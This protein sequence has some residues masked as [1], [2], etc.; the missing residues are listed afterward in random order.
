[1][2]NG[3]SVLAIVLAR[4]G[5]TRLP[6]K[7]TLPFGSDTVVGT[8]IELAKQ[9]D[10][11]DEVVLATSTSADDTLFE[12]IAL[13]HGITLIRGSENDVVARMRKAV[14]GATANH[15]V[16]VR[17]CADNPLFMPP[18]VD[19]G[20]RTLAATGADML[21]P[22]EHATLPFGYA[23]VVMT[24]ECLERIDAE[25]DLPMYREHVENF[26]L[27]N[28]ERFAIHYQMAP[29][30]MH[31]PEL[32][33]TLDYP[34]DYMRLRAME[35]MVAD[36]PLSSRAA[37]LICRIK[38]C[39]VG[40]TGVSNAIVERLTPLIERHCGT[41]PVVIDE[42]SGTQ[43]GCDLL[44]SARPVQGTLLERCLRGAIWVEERPGDGL[45][46]VYGHREL[47]SPYDVGGF[48]GESG[49]FEYYLGAQM[50]F[51]LKRFLPGFPPG[52]GR[53]VTAVPHRDK[54]TGEALRQGF[55]SAQAARFPEV[56]AVEEGEWPRNR[57]NVD[58]LL[59]LAAQHGGCV[60]FESMIN[61]DNVLSGQVGNASS[62]ER[63]WGSLVWSPYAVLGISGSGRY[64]GCDW[65]GHR[66][67]IGE[68]ASMSV[69]EAWNASPM[70]RLRANWV[71]A[72]FG[73]ESRA[74]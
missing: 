50:E 8:V 66:V 11:V 61:E 59:I 5:A 44:F 9:C 22:W 65:Q 72:K 33:L 68:V 62:A 37:E 70:Q 32:A 51:S 74:V 26:C 58:A 71:N 57:E 19:E 34:E 55:S 53:H 49:S 28:P 31:Y 45:G 46:L 30:D 6:G 47:E 12:P 35:R 42:N 39:D 7:M 23:Q 63:T 13:E 48:S 4:S 52:N 27:D 18:V 20:I 60:V 64:F 73:A 69:A 38:R 16:L 3:K 43:S 25:T 56:L 17:V 36:V 2:I 21:T 40:L 10:L 41:P 54:T 1:M 67:D 15:D 24:R 29:T 14:D